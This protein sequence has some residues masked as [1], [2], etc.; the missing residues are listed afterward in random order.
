[1]K[2]KRLNRDFFFNSKEKP[3][4]VKSVDGFAL[5]IDPSLHKTTFVLYDP[6]YYGNLLKNEI[7]S[8]KQAY[9]KIPM[10]DGANFEKFYS[11]SNVQDVML[12]HK[13]IYGYLVLTKGRELGL[14]KSC[15]KANEV[16]SLAT[17]NGY[18]TLM[19][20]IAMIQDSPIMPKR[21]QS[22]YEILKFWQHLKGLSSKIETEKFSNEDALHKKDEDDCKI[23]GNSTLDCSYSLKSE[24]NLQKLEKNH[25]MF[26]HQME[27][28]FDSHG[29]DFVQKRIK[30]YI[31]G[32]GRYF[33]DSFQE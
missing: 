26:L 24:Y 23:L 5:F 1:M 9:L 18:T 31:S 3:G 32:A 21:E 29:V 28:F 11:F 12:D 14:K 30:E 19:L 4:T 17:K 7:I 10:K 22:S 8:A 16:R 20:L 27:E 13:K 2:K 33:L 15:L 6:A 25:E